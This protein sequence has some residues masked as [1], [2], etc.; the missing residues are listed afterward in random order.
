M[1]SWTH[2]KL[3]MINTITA[4]YLVNNFLLW[5][6]QLPVHFG[7]GLDVRAELMA[8]CINRF[9]QFVINDFRGSF[10]S[11]LFEIFNSAENVFRQRFKHAKI[12][13][14]S[15]ACS[16]NQC[17]KHSNAD[18]HYDSQACDILMTG[19]WGLGW[20]DQHTCDVSKRVASV[21]KQIIIKCKISRSQ[22]RIEL[23]HM[24]PTSYQT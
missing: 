4:Q 22:A 8:I 17:N 10:N 7:F 5:E 14:W 6:R 3:Q 2:K 24:G 12:S 9:H 21:R 11:R 13:A 16:Q 1:R 19:Q 15:D 20:R 18:F 23:S